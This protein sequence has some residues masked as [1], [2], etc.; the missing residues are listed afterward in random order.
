[1]IRFVL[2][3][4]AQ[5]IPLLIGIT[6]VTFVVVDLAPGERR[7]IRISGEAKRWHRLARRGLSFQ[8]WRANDDTASS[9]GPLTLER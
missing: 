4:V 9:T 3:R 8:V 2:R 5:M 1:M 6:F 7:R